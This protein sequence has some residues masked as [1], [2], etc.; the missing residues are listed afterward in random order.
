MRKLSFSLGN[1][2]YAMYWKPMQMTTEELKDKLSKPFRTSETVEE[3]H[4]MGKAE[5]DT[6]KDKGG[7]VAGT[8][9]GTRRKKE[10]VLSRSMLCMDGD[11]LRQYFLEEYEATHRFYTLYYATHSSLPEAPRAGF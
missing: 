7:F 2:R 4:K 5:K 3:Y 10:D 6:I 11:E 9:K 1:N 8:L